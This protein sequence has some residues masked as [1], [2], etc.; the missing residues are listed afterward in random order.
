MYNLGALYLDGQVV[1]RDEI[2]AY[3]WFELSAQVGVGQELDNA[4]G[5]LRTPEGTPYSLASRNGNGGSE[6]LAARHSGTVPR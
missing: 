1:A 4:L 6:R 5:A 2:E 3:K